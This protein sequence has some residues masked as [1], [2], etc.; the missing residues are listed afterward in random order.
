MLVMIDVIGYVE[1]N[2][3]RVHVTNVLEPGAPI[4]VLKYIEQSLHAH[5][6]NH[7]KCK[8]EKV[9]LKYEEHVKDGT[10]LEF[11]RNPPIVIVFIEIIYFF[12]FVFDKKL[13]QSY[14]CPL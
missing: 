9:K 10:D 4:I 6:S 3:Q 13:L 7:N 11:L 14:L 1:E 12:Y 8:A 2:V 5:L